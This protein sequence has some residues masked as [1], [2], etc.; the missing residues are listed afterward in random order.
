MV[1]S[2]GPQQLYR[3]GILNEVKDLDPSLSNP[4]DWLSG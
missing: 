1:F 3:Y 4:T 2:P